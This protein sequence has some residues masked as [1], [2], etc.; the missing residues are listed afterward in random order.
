[1]EEEAAAAAAEEP[2]PGAA[3]VGDSDEWGAGDALGKAWLKYSLKDQ[4]AKTVKQTMRVERRCNGRA[5]GD[6]Q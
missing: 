4:T 1:M 3:G 2:L 6:G 5:A